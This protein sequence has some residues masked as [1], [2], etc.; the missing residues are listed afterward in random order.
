MRISIRPCWKRFIINYCSE[1]FVAIVEFL[2]CKELVHD[3]G[4]VISEKSSIRNQKQ[5]R[6]SN[7]IE[8][9]R[10]EPFTYYVCWSHRLE[11]KTQ[12]KYSYHIKVNDRYSFWL[13]YEVCMVQ[14]DSVLWFIILEQLIYHPFCDRIWCFLLF[15][16]TVKHL[17]WIHNFKHRN[18]LSTKNLKWLRYIIVLDPPFNDAFQWLMQ[19]VETYVLLHLINAS[20][21]HVR[22]LINLFHDC[23]TN[24]RFEW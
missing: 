20:Q 1:K 9:W 11:I 3:F 19:H 10:E 2:I 12:F 24:L 16:Q 13:T 7:W 18:T 4:A 8:S 17:L 14:F 22:K 15:L 21:I 6:D 5:K 23:I